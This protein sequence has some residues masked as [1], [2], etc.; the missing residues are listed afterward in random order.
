MSWSTQPVAKDERKIKLPLPHK[1]IQMTV[2]EMILGLFYVIY[3]QNCCPY[4]VIL[5]I[6]TYVNL[7]VSGSV[8]VYYI[9]M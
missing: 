3:V 1:L 7:E 6:C 5:A 9:A 4:Y 2:Y 8:F